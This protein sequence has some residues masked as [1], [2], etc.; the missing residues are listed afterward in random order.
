MTT[1]TQI[2]GFTRHKAPSIPFPAALAA[3]GIVYG[4]MV[5]SARAR[6]TR[7]SKQWMPVA[8]CHLK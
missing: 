2:D 6:S 7:S 4:S 5:I 8:H 3:L 1:A